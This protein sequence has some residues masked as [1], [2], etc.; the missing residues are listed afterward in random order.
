MNL[1]GALP[2]G[3]FLKFM[4]SRFHAGGLKDPENGHGPARRDPVRP[5]A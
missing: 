4:G 3:E 5:L 2:S 1:V